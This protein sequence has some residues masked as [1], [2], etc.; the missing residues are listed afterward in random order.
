MSTAN[1]SNVILMRHRE[2]LEGIP[3]KNAS[4]TLTYGKSTLAGQNAV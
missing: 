4:G 3:I 2:I 1:A